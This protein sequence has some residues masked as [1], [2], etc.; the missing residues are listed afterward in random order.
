M[1]LYEELGIAGVI[2]AAGRLTA[3]GGS[4][5]REEAIAAMAEAGRSHV[6]LAALRRAA[7]A[8]I[9]RLA[10]APA[11]TV[12]AGAAA[13]LVMAVA[14]CIAGTDLALINRLPDS[15]GL[16]NRVPIQA[17]HLINFGAPVEQMIR[18]GGGVPAPI[19]SVNTVRPRDLEAVLEAGG[20]ACLMFV[21]SHHAVQ[22]N[23]LTLEECV[24]LCRRTGVPVIADAAAEEDLQRYLAAGADLVA[25]SG[26]KALEGPTT[27]VLLGRPDLVAAADAQMSGVARPM[28]VGKEDILGLV[29]ALRCYVH[30]DES[31]E[32]ERQ[33]AVLEALQERLGELPGMNQ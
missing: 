22:I 4:A 27:G 18:L 9:A 19:G 2:N 11:A 12:T 26:G 13:S 6:D 23:G 24:A 28:K 25:Y 20:V 31:A 15:H 7:G 5:L 17:G 29:A 30:R 10:G 8:E 33:R 21:V 1:G 3:L 16:V 32:R 14:G